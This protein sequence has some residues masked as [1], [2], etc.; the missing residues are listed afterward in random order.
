L[1]VGEVRRAMRSGHSG[2]RAE[3][4]WA[5]L[6]VDQQP[7]AL[8]EVADGALERA[9]EHGSTGH[10]ER[11]PRAGQRVFEPRLEVA[12]EARHLRSAVATSE[13]AV[14]A[15]RSRPGLRPRLRGGEPREGATG[16]LAD[17][18]VDEQRV[19]HL[20]LADGCGEP[21]TEDR[22]R[23]DAERLPHAGGRAVEP[24]LQIVFDLYDVLAP[25][26]LPK[27][28]IAARLQ[29]PAAVPMPDR[30]QSLEHIAAVVAA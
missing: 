22:P 28:S 12:F 13:N 9:T 7:V 27:D 2:E 23:P 21:G 3:R 29:L 19:A 5:D 8:L 18:T 24:R 20:E 6:A 26:A 11:L 14:P 25:V 16:V 15:P 30:A 17:L 4:L 1:Q 10:T